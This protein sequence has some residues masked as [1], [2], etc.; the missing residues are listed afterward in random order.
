MTEM[1]CGLKPCAGEAHAPMTI[2]GNAIASAVLSPG[3]VVVPLPVLSPAHPLSPV[4]NIDTMQRSSNV[5]VQQQ[6]AGV[7]FQQHA[8]IPVP[9]F[10]PLRHPAH[11][12]SPV[13]NIDTMQRNSD[14]AV[15]QQCAGVEFQQPWGPNLPLTEH[16]WTAAMASPPTAAMVS[17]PTAAMV[18][19][20]TAAMCPPGALVSPVLMP[21]PFTGTTHQ[22]AQRWI[23]LALPHYDCSLT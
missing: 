11:P 17:P 18:S 7:E 16:C 21:S 13:H 20:P 23:A 3:H 6:C 10:S 8:M 19:P 22:T 2:L 15:Q 4:R 1:D 9:Q 14:V 5:A 12:L